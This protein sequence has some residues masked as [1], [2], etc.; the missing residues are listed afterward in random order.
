M[1]NLTQED[2][3]NQVND[4]SLCPICHTEMTMEKHKKKTHYSKEKTVYKCPICGFKHRKRTQNEI[5]RDMGLRDEE[6]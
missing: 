3:E 4:E 5:L 1:K 6:F 2:F